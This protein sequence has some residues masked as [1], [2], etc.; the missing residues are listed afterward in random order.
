MIKTK[1]IASSG[2]VTISY[3]YDENGIVEFVYINQ[4]DDAIEMTVQ[5]YNDLMEDLAR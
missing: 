2:D 5:Q 1:E 4:G 3:G